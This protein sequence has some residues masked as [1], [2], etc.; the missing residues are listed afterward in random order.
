MDNVSVD[1]GYGVERFLAEVEARGIA[2]HV[3]VRGK[4]DVRPEPEEPRRTVVGFAAA[5]SVPMKRLGVR[6]RNRAVKANETRGYQISRKL[7]LR[8]EHLFGEAK[9][10]HGLR[11]ARY[12]GLAK[13]ERQMILTAVAINL[14]RLAASLG[15]QRSQANAVAKRAK[16]ARFAQISILN[17]LKMALTKF[18]AV[19]TAMLTP[20][21]LGGRDAAVHA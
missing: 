9:T 2:A 15:R 12:R 19:M 21:L 7:R 8:I 10:C 1:A 16:K 11:R 5:R 13:V 20:V 17:R 3:P 4:Q 14:R 18:H 6:G